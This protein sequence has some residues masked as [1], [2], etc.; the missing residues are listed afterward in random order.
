MAEQETVGAAL[1]ALSRWKRAFSG[2]AWL[3]SDAERALA[4]RLQEA[5]GEI[6]GRLWERRRPS[7]VADL[8]SVQ[9]PLAARLRALVEGETGPLAEVT[10]AVDAYAAAWPEPDP[11]LAR[12][13]QHVLL[14]VQ[15]APLLHTS[16][17]G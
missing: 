10:R 7:E 13:R 6:V 11:S 4:G 5:L 16:I 3:P 8:A 14:Y 17:S 1:Q 9:H 15:L 12:E 2:G